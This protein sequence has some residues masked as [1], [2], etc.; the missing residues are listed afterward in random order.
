MIPSFLQFSNADKQAFDVWSLPH[1][2]SGILIGFPGLWYGMNFMSSFWILII[3][4]AIFEVI[5]IITKVNEP[6]SN[7]LLDII[8]GIV[9]FLIT[10]YYF[11]SL[12][13]SFQ[14]M[15]FTMSALIY[16][17]VIIPG[18]LKYIKSKRASN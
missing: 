8:L 10:Y 15:I 12:N 11:I 1:F 2:L 6:L 5:E 17:S 14:K 9:A 18:W 16:L 4:S 3:L 7:K 13:D